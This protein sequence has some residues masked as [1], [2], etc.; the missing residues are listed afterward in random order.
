MR[1]KVVVFK[2]KEPVSQQEMKQFAKQLDKIDG[3]DML[4][5]PSHIDVQVLDLSTGETRAKFDFYDPV[6]YVQDLVKEEK[7]EILEE[8]GRDPVKDR[9][10]FGGSSMSFG[11]ISGS[12]ISFN[13]TTTGSPTPNPIWC[14]AGS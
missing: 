12:V 5:L 1:D 9:D 4:V 14:T 8:I 10:D 3:K 6:E 13:M 7:T 2:F 11:G